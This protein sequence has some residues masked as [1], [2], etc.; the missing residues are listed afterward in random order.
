MLEV[1]IFRTAAILVFGRQSALDEIN[2]D[3]PLWY[4]LQTYVA[5]RSVRAEVITG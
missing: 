1:L 2:V 3:Y 5:V 4:K